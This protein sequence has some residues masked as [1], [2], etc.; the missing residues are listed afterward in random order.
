M[1]VGSAM[2]RYA[3]SVYPGGCVVG[4]TKTLNWL[5]SLIPPSFDVP[6]GAA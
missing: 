5:G 4:P 2:A 1:E 6:S 3:A